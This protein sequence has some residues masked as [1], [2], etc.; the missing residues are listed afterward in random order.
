MKSEKKSPR[1]EQPSHGFPQINL[2]DEDDADKM[3]S[4]SKDKKKRTRTLGSPFGAKEKGRKA[5]SLEY[6]SKQ[7]VKAIEYHSNNNRRSTTSNDKRAV[8]TNEPMVIKSGWVIV[9]KQNSFCE[10]VKSGWEV[11]LRCFSKILVSMVRPLPLLLP[12]FADY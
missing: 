7:Q 8:N 9:N 10:L 5:T 1:G 2:D 3:L 6:T 12:P 11:K 4:N